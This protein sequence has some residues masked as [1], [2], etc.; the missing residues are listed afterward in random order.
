MQPKNMKMTLVE[1]DGKFE[2]HILNSFR[3]LPGELIAHY[4]SNTIIIGEQE[5]AS[6]KTATKT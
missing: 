6:V 3:V 1:K 2:A 5:A 4:D